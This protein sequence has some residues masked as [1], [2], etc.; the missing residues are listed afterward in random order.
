MKTVFFVRHAKSSWKELGL[1]DFERPLNNRG[2]RDAPFMGKLLSNTIQTPDL[3]LSSSAKRAYK[4]AK[5]F[6]E[7]FDVSKNKIKKEDDLYHSDTSEILSQLHQLED[8]VDSVMLFIHNP[9]ITDIVNYC[10]K[11]NIFNIPTCAVAGIEFPVENWQQVSN[12]GH[13]MIYEYPKKYY[14]DSGKGPLL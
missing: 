13:L 4:T 2:L 6:A 5:I 3:F 1:T 10:T 11:S 9:G 14:N 7:Q 8:K 12:N